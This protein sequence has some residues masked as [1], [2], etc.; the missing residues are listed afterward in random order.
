L[1]K[2]FPTTKVLE[3]G[4]DLSIYQEIVS[5]SIFSFNNFVYKDDTSE[6]IEKCVCEFIEKTIFDLLKE[7][8][9]KFFSSPGVS[10]EKNVYSIEIHKIIVKYESSIHKESYLDVKQF[11]L[12][13]EFNKNPISITLKIK[14]IDFF[15]TIENSDELI[16]FIQTITSRFA[17]VSVDIDEARRIIIKT[18]IN[19]QNSLPSFFKKIIEKIDF[20]LI[21]STAFY[22]VCIRTMFYYKATK[23]IIKYPIFVNIMKNLA[24]FHEN[25]LN[26]LFP[27]I[28]IK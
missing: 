9:S 10:N 26:C 3:T 2:R 27:E 6:N 8:N 7:D 21:I 4:L 13:I 24:K 12:M 16:F 19:H 20:L 1:Y 11:L 25:E 17:E 23:E 15:M 14:L 5:F 28:K 18:N 22:N